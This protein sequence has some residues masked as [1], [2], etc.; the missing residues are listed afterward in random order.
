MTENMKERL[1]WYVFVNHSLLHSATVLQHGVYPGPDG[2]TPGHCTQHGVCP[3]PD[4]ST[5]G[6]CTQTARCVPGTRRV[7]TWT[8]RDG[9]TSLTCF[10]HRTTSVMGRGDCADIGV[11]DGQW[12]GG[13]GGRQ[14]PPPP[15][16]PHNLSKLIYPVNFRQNWGKIRA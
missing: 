11:W 15:P 5:P 7:Y 4:G 13:G 6:H 3:G 8:R 1:S 14:P 16:P 10:S 2:S 12:G 9:A